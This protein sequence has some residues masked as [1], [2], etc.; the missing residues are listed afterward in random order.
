MDKDSFISKQIFKLKQIFNTMILHD[1]N[2]KEW[3]KLKGKYAGK[4]VFLIGN[5]PSLNETPLFMLR[6][7]YTMSLNR[8]YMLH[9]RLNWH[10]SFYMCVDPVVV[11]DIASEINKQVS[12]YSLS[13]F[14][15]IHKEYIDPKPN[16]LWIHG[17]VPNWYSTYIPLTGKAATVAFYAL[18]VLTYL[19]FNEIY[20]VGVDQ[21]Y[22]LHTTVK[23]IKGREIESVKDDDPNHFDPRYFGKG[24]KYHQADA[25]MAREMIESF[26]VAYKASQKHNFTIYN[27]GFNSQLNVFERKNFYDVLKLNDAESLALFKQSFPEKIATEYVDQ[28]LNKDVTL[29][30]HE[31]NYSNEESFVTNVED[32]KK[33]TQKI[34]YTHIPFGPYQDKIFFVKRT[35]A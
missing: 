23:T 11:P 22:Q 17:M 21:N 12:N 26:E 25:N 31:K 1:N 15:S 14:L 20:L 35:A 16:V 2:A 18:Q 28:L 10:P 7:E 8:F 33:L 27:A 19:G 3:K 5:G 6:N 30:D 13:A 4:R 34:I 32:G 24:R 9:E 29:V